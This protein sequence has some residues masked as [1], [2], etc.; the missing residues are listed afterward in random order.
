MRLFIEAMAKHLPPSASQL[1][2][3]DV[4]GAAGEVLSALRHDLDTLSLSSQTPTWN[5]ASDSV[6]AVTAYA[7]ALDSDFLSAALA[8]L[9][10]G[11]RLIVVLPSGVVS[12]E[13]VKT[14]EEAGYTRILVELAVGQMGVLVRGEKPHTEQRTHDRIQQV[15]VRDTNVLDLTTYNGR[16]IHLLI[17]QTPNKPAWKLA[18]D[19]RIE[20]RAVALNGEDGDTLLAFSSLPK[21]VAFMQPVVMA[22]KIRDVNRV[23]KFS[24]ETV[25]QWTFPVVLNPTVEMLE[26]RVVALVQIDS[27]TAETPDE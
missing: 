26:G 7:I 5:L 2:L 18:P 1:R 8:T 4:N 6:D 27:Q 20:W 14:L 23:A 3:L 25:G 21:A 16:Y 10:P 22:G 24:R 9:R 19:E 17:R 11:G 13:W 12:E 15:A